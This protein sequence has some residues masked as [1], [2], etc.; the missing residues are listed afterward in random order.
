M[1]DDAVPADTLVN[2]L[3]GN[4]TEGRHSDSWTLDEAADEIERLAEA[5]KLVDKF[6]CPVHS[7]AA[8]PEDYMLDPEGNVWPPYEGHYNFCGQRPKLAD[9]LEGPTDADA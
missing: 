8:C 3:R 5:L 9:F 6:R 7:N 4:T 1:T 2:R